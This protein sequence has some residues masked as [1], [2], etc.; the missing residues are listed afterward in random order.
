MRFSQKISFSLG[1]SFFL[2]TML[3]ISVAGRTYKTEAVIGRVVDVNPDFF[4]KQDQFY[5]QVMSDQTNSMI[6]LD[7]RDDLYC[8]V[9][10][11]V[12]FVQTTCS[13]FGANV[14]EFISCGF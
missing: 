1:A 3:L 4:H 9:G 5:L 7:I 2:L 6:N 8:P 14:Y 12:V 10:A 13:L 11:Q